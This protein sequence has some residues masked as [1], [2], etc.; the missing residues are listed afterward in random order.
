MFHALA[1]NL[2]CKAFYLSEA[3]VSD[4]GSLSLILASENNELADEL[5]ATGMEIHQTPNGFDAIRMALET[6]PDVIILDELTTG[7]PTPTVAIWLKLNPITSSVPVIG[8]SAQNYGWQEAQLDAQVPPNS[9]VEKLAEVIHNLVGS[10][11][12]LQIADDEEDWSKFDPLSIT[13]DLIEIYRERLG[14][15]SAMIELAS[16]QHDLGDPEYTIKSILE[17]AGRALGSKLMGI[18]LIKDHTHYALVRDSGF[19][20]EHM[21]GLQDYALDRLQDYLEKPFEIDK[22]LVIGRRRL[23]DEPTAETSSCGFYGYPVESRGEMIGILTGVTTGCD[24]HA[25]YTASLLPDLTAQIALLLVNAELISTQESYVSELSSILRAVAETSSVSSFTDSDSKGFLLQFL[26][27]MLELC[28]TD[29]G[30][31]VILN[32]EKN[33]FAETTSF[34]CSE[35]EVLTTGYGKG[36]TL[37]H[38]LVSMPIGEVHVDQ[39]VIGEN[40]LTRIITPLA[41]GEELMGGVVVLTYEPVIS[42]RIL[43][44][45]LTLA[46]LAGHL[47]KNN[48]MHLKIIESSI[49]EGQ[50]NIA[51]DVQAEMIPDEHPDFPGYDIFGRSVPARE[52]GGDFFDY[53]PREN[54]LGVAIADVCGKSIP[55]SLLMTMSRAFFLA[56]NES[57]RGPEAILQSVNTLLTRSITNGKFVTGSLMFLNEDGFSYACAGHQ[58][59]MIYRAATNEF[60]EIS[61]EG[62][63]L[64]ILEDMDFERKDLK[65]NPG[66]IAVLYTDGLNEAMNVNRDQFGYENLKLIIQMNNDK[67]S[68]EIV[69][70]L[71]DAIEKHA[72]GADQSDDTTV[73]AI[74]KTR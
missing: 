45:I 26:L 15:A 41:A 50:L 13:I 34:G 16:L 39:T 46:S 37:A 53:F 17:A 54:S 18:T 42:P 7:L 44:A 51:R 35:E 29:K 47:L 31:V 11:P 64:G 67:G 38:E 30:C 57:G 3:S 27:I 74:K 33:A 59:V 62:I 61:A 43:E 9:S 22:E 58:P 8:L 52:V 14:L 63:A 48:A 60:E 12:N 68:E 40:K 71:F 65:M 20:K 55:A 1:V 4:K 25:A 10:A 32:E 5:R 72:D 6:Q 23:G 49:I 19:T 66:D 21:L 69:N 2:Y 70:A 73:V 36:R 56:E 28:R 24:H